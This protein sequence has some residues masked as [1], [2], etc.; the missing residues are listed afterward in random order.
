MRE[1]QEGENIF[2]DHNNNDACRQ[3]TFNSFNIC[4]RE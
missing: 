2:N 1:I 4:D 3:Y